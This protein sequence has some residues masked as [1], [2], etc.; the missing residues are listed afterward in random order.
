MPAQHDPIAHRFVPDP[1]L[2][3]RAHNLLLEQEEGRPTQ[4]YLRQQW[5]AA[6]GAVRVAMDALRDIWPLEAR[7]LGEPAQLFLHQALDDVE[8]AY[9]SL[10]SIAEVMV[11]DLMVAIQNGE[12]CTHEEFDAWI[13]DH[14]EA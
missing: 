6:F 5:D 12:I 14:D 8:N 11:G 9:H 7:Q 13:A 10:D 3:H 1:T 2:V 4:R